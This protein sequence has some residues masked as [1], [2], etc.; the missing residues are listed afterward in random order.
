MIIGGRRLQ[1]VAEDGS[2]V[3]TD[4]TAEADYD[5]VVGCE[6]AWSK[7]RN[8]LSDERPRHLGLGYYLLRIVDAAAASPALRRLVNGGNLFAHHEGQKL[9][10]QQ[11]RDGGLHVTWSFRA[12]E[13]WLA[14][15][16]GHPR[17]PDQAR[18]AILEQMHD[19][20]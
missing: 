7:V 20:V 1:R 6:G 19:W 5:L 12:P 17:D 14:A 18:A 10:V 11:L 2:L 9:S 16:A 15:E 13:D 4:G 8:H 3:F